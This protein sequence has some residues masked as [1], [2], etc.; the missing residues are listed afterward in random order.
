[1]AVIEEAPVAEAVV[2][3]SA[4]AA[5]IPAAEKPAEKKKEKRPVAA[6]EEEDGEVSKD[7][8]NLDEL[9]QMKPEMFQ[10]EE[11]ADDDADKKKG[12]KGKKKSVALEFDEDLGEVVSRKKHKRGDEE[13]EAW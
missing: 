9:F 10:S 12:K 6:E 11:G 3:E 7:G 2:A 8:V 4:P 5:E 1:V 13:G